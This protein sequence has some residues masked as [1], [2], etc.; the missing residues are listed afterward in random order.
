MTRALIVLLFVFI[1]CSDQ[2][3][4]PFLTSPAKASSATPSPPAAMAI[5]AQSAPLAQAQ[6]PIA[7]EAAPSPG[8]DDS[9]VEGAMAGLI[10]A[11]SRRDTEGFLKFVSKKRS[12]RYLGTVEKPYRTELV[13]YSELEKDLTSK[14]QNGGW[15][16]RL[17]DAGP[18][19]A[20]SYFAERSQGRAWKQVE[21]NKFVPPDA[22][23]DSPIFVVWRNLEGRWVIQYI[24]DPGV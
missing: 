16:V 6:Q 3:S 2:Q 13:Q 11:L 1:G 23:S 21:E 19:I 10:D 5:T 14:E 17:F 18:D 20:F 4:V 24:G 12:F 15:Y 9:T 7:I 8:L 22:S